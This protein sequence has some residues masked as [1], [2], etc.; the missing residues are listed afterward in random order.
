MF[1]NSTQT[2]DESDVLQDQMDDSISLLNQAGEEQQQ[3]AI[4]QN[5]LI[6][7]TTGNVAQTIIKKGKGAVLKA[8]KRAIQTAVTAGLITQGMNPQFA[9]LGGSAVGAA[10]DA[11]YNFTMG[12][13][14]SSTSG[15]QTTTNPMDQPK[16]SKHILNQQKRNPENEVE[17]KGRR[18]RTKYR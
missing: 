4:N 13:S 17:P 8:G 11:G 6:L 18:G 3:G 12:G 14:S 7:N 15:M 10:L 16:E 9:G 1:H 5:Q 2:T